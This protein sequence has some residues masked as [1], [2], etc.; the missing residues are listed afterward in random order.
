M[1]LKTLNEN[2][3]PWVEIEGY[4]GYEVSPFGRVLNS[5]TGLVLQPGISNGYP[6]I[7]LCGNNKKKKYS[8]HRLVANAFINNPENKRCVDHIDNNRTNNHV[9]NLRWA[10]YEEN[11]MNRSIGKYN[12]SGY[13]GVRFYKSRK[14]W[15]AR[16]TVDGIQ[17]HIGYYKTLDEAVQARKDRANEAFGAYVNAC[18]KE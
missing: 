18:E 16:I 12:T 15:K 7:N 10:S 14:K 13:K 1:E 3:E 11:S 17:I 5:N 2:T 9:T 8:I 4:P 6:K